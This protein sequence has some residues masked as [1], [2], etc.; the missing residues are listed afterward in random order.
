MIIKLETVGTSSHGR[1]KLEI[2]FTGF[3]SI[4]G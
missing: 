4:W 1:L 3:V 2:E